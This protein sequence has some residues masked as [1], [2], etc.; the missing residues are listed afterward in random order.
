[1][2]DRFLQQA[3]REYSERQ[4][5]VA[6]IPEAIF[7]VILLP[8]ALVWAG[9]ALD[10]ALQWPKFYF[11]PV[12]LP[13]GILLIA[14]GWPFALWSIYAQFTRGRGTPVPLMATQKLVVEPPYTYCRNPMATG[15]VLAYL[16][17]SV[18]AGSAGA[19]LLAVL[20]GVILFTYIKWVEEKEMVLRFGQEYLEYRR[21]TP[22]LI[23]R[24]RKKS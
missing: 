19:A 9:G 24:F 8:L 16:G 20:G 18:L 3:R 5:L 14:L 10:Q 1:M 11:A 6:F 13:I 22:F 12:N 23:P 15:A 17:V 7:F 4:R 2:K 21:Q